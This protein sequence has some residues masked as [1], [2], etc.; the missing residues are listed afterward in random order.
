MGVRE[1]GFQ[2][3]H[4]VLFLTYNISMY[5]SPPFPTHFGNL[6]T[7][8]L[9]FSDWLV[10]LKDASQRG[11]LVVQQIR[12][13][14]QCRG[15]GFDPWSGNQNLH[16]TTKTQSCQTN[17]YFLKKDALQGSPA[18]LTSRHHFCFDSCLYSTLSVCHSLTLSVLYEE[19]C[20]SPFS[21]LQIICSENPFTPFTSLCTQ[22]FNL[23]GQTECTF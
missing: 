9:M 7:L 3:F 13:C 18:V 23:L 10:S 17:K 5:T 14:S 21:L 15:P 8:S 1:K 19:M 12:L 16:A 22:R 20:V 2:Q 11:F 4:G 6:I